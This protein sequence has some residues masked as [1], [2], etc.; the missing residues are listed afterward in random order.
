GSER[1]AHPAVLPTG[2]RLCPAASACPAPYSAIFTAMTVTGLPPFDPRLAGTTP[3]SSAVS[4]SRIVMGHLSLS[5]G[6]VFRNL[7]KSP[8]VMALSSLLLPHAP[9]QRTGRRSGA[10]VLLAR[11]ETAGADSSGERATTVDV[12]WMTVQVPAP[13]APQLVPGDH[14]TSNSGSV[15]P[16]ASPTG[17]RSSQ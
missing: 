9:N 8:T 10:W 14:Q 1:T 12:R 6:S 13:A 16:D 7:R 5:S 11:A 15:P 4:R 2:P 17:S 3:N